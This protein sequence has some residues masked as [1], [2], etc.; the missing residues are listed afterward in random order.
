M[1]RMNDRVIAITGA[2]SG[3]GRA[4]A[5]RLAKRGAKLALAD[6]NVE[7]LAET[8]RL[9]GNSHCV[10]QVFDVTDHTAL[11]AFCAHAA[12]SFGHLDGIINNAGLSVVAPFEQTP[13]EDFNR[14]MAVN[15]DAV[16]EGCRVALPYLKG[17]SERTWLVNISSIFGIMPFETQTAYCASKYAV[18]GFTET[19]RIELNQTD[20]NIAVICVHPG[21]IKTAVLRN[22]KYIGT[23]DDAS[24]SMMTAENFEKVAPT[25][26]EAAADA[27]IRAMEL[28]KVRLRIGNDAR[29]VDWLVRLMPV[30]APRILGGLLGIITR[31]AVR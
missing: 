1:S 5:L 6:R 18:R 3:I 13:R 12:D 20:P 19:L 29:M 9:L 2:G 22:A 11:A 7:G 23:V 10:S 24:A 4:L 15:F 30:S 8:Q 26:P 27:I 21:G 28:N 17:R 14:V 25:T 31:I 16:V